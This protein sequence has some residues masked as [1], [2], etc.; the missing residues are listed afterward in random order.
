MAIDVQIVLGI[1]A[2]VVIVLYTVNN[3]RVSRKRTELIEDTMK[4]IS[5]NTVD[6]I[7]IDGGALNCYKVLTLTSGAE[8]VVTVELYD[9]DHDKIRLPNGVTINKNA[10]ES[11]K[12]RY[13]GTGILYSRT[14]SIVELMNFPVFLV[15]ESETSIKRVY[16]RELGGDSLRSGRVFEGVVEGKNIHW[17]EDN[18]D[19]ILE[20]KRIV[21]NENQWLGWNRVD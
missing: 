17:E 12:N 20:E 5:E 6:S 1:V 2:F 21:R 15:G 8:Y 7:R 19:I 9:S 16:T 10:I 13:L 11:Y 3:M 14:H 18:F 4:I